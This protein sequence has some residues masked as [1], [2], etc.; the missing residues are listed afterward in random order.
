MG[1]MISALGETST[2]SAAHSR[3]ETFFEQTAYNLWQILQAF[4]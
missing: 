4:I 3:I 2:S 1:K